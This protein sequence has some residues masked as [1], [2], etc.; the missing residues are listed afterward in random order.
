MRGAGELGGAA[1][2]G[3]S[4]ALLLGAGQMPVR[5][6]G[7]K[8]SIGSGAAIYKTEASAKRALRGYYA[9]RKGKGKRR[10]SK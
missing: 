4:P 1:P 3:V 7:N 8:W 10:A 2:W 6:K 5:K 9:N